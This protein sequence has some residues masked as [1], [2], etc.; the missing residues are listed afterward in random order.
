MSEQRVERIVNTW[1][2]NPENVGAMLKVDLFEI[3]GSI[4][5]C[6][7]IVC[8]FSFPIKRFRPIPQEQRIRKTYRRLEI[9]EIYRHFTRLLCQNDP[10]PS[11][12]SIEEKPA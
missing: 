1:I 11:R 8:N 3:A 4:A 7:G 10:G 9:S 2:D 12:P 5:F 6:L